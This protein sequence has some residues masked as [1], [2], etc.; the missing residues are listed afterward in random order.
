MYLRLTGHLSDIIHGLGRMRVLRFRLKGVVAS[1]VGMLML[2]IYIAAATVLDGGQNTTLSSAAR[3]HLKDPFAALNCGGVERMSTFDHM[4][5]AQRSSLFEQLNTEDRYMCIR[6]ISGKTRFFGMVAFT[7]AASSQSI[8]L[9]GLPTSLSKWRS[10]IAQGDTCDFMSLNDYRDAF[11]PYVDFLRVFEA[12]EEA[13]KLQQHMDMVYSN[14]NRVY[15]YDGRPQLAGTTHICADLVLTPLYT[16]Y[17]LKTIHKHFRSRGQANILKILGIACQLSD[18]MQSVGAEQSRS[19][20]LSLGSD[21]EEIPVP[22]SSSRNRFRSETYLRRK[23]VNCH[24]ICKRML[25]WKPSHQKAASLSTCCSQCE[26]PN[27]T[28]DPKFDLLLAASSVYDVARVRPY[29][30]FAIDLNSY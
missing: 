30:P 16:T 14:K 7:F 26:G 29:R 20:N 21:N 15:Y 2:S 18:D 1:F 27:C 24:P 28:L 19:S 6:D 4:T 11:K 25:R 10:R 17:V 22:P 3:V 8:L 23:F 13:K 9:Q 5:C 12:N